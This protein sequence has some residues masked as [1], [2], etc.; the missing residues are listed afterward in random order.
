MLILTYSRIVDFLRHAKIL[1]LTFLHVSESPLYV[2]KINI[3]F[4]TVQ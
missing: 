3:L 2:F 1:I 4:F